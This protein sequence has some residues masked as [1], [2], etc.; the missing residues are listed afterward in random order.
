MAYNRITVTIGPNRKESEWKNLASAVGL[1]YV[2][3][4]EIRSLY[5][6]DERPK[7]IEDLVAGTLIAAMRRHQLISFR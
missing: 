1:R 7:Y 3:H 2:Q 4:L 5:G 6:E